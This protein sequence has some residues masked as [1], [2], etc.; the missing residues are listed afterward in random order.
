MAPDASDAIPLRD[1]RHV[2][3]RSVER[4]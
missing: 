1:L 2:Q 3:R 4:L